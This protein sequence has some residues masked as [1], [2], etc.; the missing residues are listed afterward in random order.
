MRAGEKPYFCIGRRRR[1]IQTARLY[2]L[3]VLQGPS[4]SVEVLGSDEG[5]EQF[6]LDNQ[7]LSWD[8]V[9]L[10]DG[11][12]SLIFGHRSYLAEVMAWHEEDRILDLRISGVPCRVKI[13]DPL[14]RT[15]KTLGLN[16]ASTHRVSE[17][18]APMP[19][20]VVRV[21]AVQGQALR[22]GDPVL[23]LEAMKMENV[24]KAPADAVVREV[25][26]SEHTAVEKGQVLM[27]LE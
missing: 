25:R 26:V 2:D 13:S 22:Q 17:I 4:F 6:L 20:L 23:V 19:G 15:L 5:K 18:R 7:P 10:P 14:D 11:S 3:E 1:P 12:L 27:I 16:T 9:P 24:F 21:M 8:A